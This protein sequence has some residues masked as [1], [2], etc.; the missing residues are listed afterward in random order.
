M[1]TM[2]QSANILLLKYP[3]EYT[4]L[5]LTEHIDDLLYR[6][7]NRALG[8]TIFRVGCDLTRKLGPEDRLTGSIMMASEQNQPYQRILFVLVCACHFRATGE[9]E[10]PFP[11]DVEF[12]QLYN[13]GGLKRILTTI[14]KFNESYDHQLICQAEKMEKDLKVVGFREQMKKFL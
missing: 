13:Q 3:Y 9:D 4:L 1:E 7:Q 2:L 11:G 10:K 12:Q 5:S 14:C 6:F 8:D